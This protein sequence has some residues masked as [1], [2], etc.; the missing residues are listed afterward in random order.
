M[1]YLK[2]INLEKPRRNLVLLFCAIVFILTS[3]SNQ[4][5]KIQ[6]ATDTLKVL[7]N[8]YITTN[9][10]NRRQDWFNNHKLPIIAG[11]TINEAG[12]PVDKKLDFKN[13][14][15]AINFFEMLTL[16]QAGQDTTTG[17]RVYFASAPLESG[18]SGKLTLIFAAT[19]GKDTSDVKNYYRFKNGDLDSNKLDTVTAK[20]WVHNYQLNIRP[21]LSNTMDIKDPGA[22][23]KHIWFSLEQINSIIIEMKYQRDRHSEIVKG[24]GVRFTSYTDQDYSFLSTKPVP[25]YK[26]LTIGFTFVDWEGDDIG[27]KQIDATEFFERLKITKK[28]KGTG[29]DTLDTGDPTPPPS[30]DN[31]AALDVSNQ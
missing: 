26:R 22:E 21:K 24:F 18:K 6:I 4:Q 3:C 16:N 12:V 1:N 23:T 15:A 17:I 19:A 13:L 29:G 28:Q 11:L 10:S 7:P 20:A 25:H 5:A 8:T 30:N 27:I 2:L 31:K 14:Q 9:E